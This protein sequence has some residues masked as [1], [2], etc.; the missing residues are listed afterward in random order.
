LVGALALCAASVVS[1]PA[2]ALGARVSPQVTANVWS[3]GIEAPGSGALN[4][5]GVSGID[6][7]SCTKVGDC[8]A[9]GTYATSATADA[10]FMDVESGGTWAN[11][12]EIPGYAAL[13]VG[14]SQDV[15]ASVDCPS[16]G[17]CTVAG[18]YSGSGNYLYPFTESESNGQWSTALELTGFSVGNGDSSA[19]I[20]A[21]TCTGVGDCEVSGAYDNASITAYV[22]TESHGVWGAPVDLSGFSA[23]G[24][25]AVVFP[26]SLSCSSAGNC[27]EAG[28][29]TIG[30]GTTDVVSYVANET[31]GTWD[32]VTT[33]PGLSALD[34]ASIDAPAQISCTGTGDCVV[35]GEF[36]VSATASGGFIA[37]ESSGTWQS[38]EVVPG[39][40][41]LNAG[42]DASTDA[43]ACA[44]STTCVVGGT[45]KD[46]AGSYQA[47]VEDKTNGSW[48]SAE[49]VPG[50]STLNSGGAASIL[51]LS[52]SSAGNCGGTGAYTDNQGNVQAFVVNQSDGTWR[53]AI[54]VAGVQA[55]NQDGLAE[56]LTISCASDGSCAAGG[57]YADDVNDAQAF[58]ASSNATLSA[59]SAPSIRVVAHA[60]GEVSVSLKATVANGGDPVT[61]Y[62]YSVDGHAWTKAKSSSFSIL[63]LAAHR[64]HRVRV[65]ALNA[66]GA[67]KISA[68]VAVL[69]A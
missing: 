28:I 51:A 21:L 43:V 53:S 34:T 40:A 9:V 24:D 68:S 1:L 4:T 64:V 66:L 12:E 22:A 25:V 26:T 48:S 65:R 57:V 6:E 61:G 60:N 44:N 23:L 55:L 7:L 3:A 50:S 5:G 59:P 32:S 49:E 62:E 45:Y 17:N 46:A 8:V 31:N 38:A 52:C 35:G 27:G 10:D 37:V 63:H 13:N 15:S 39:L 42:G 29:Y 20:S 54:E 11:A 36:G 18:T 33:I 47:F 19:T 2:G 69:V 30:A 67:G 16:T 41:T 56:G 14:T 58:V